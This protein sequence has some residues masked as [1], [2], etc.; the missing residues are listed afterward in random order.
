MKARPLLERFWERVS[1]VQ[2]ACWLWRGSTTA[3]GYG[4]LGAGG[5]GGANVYAHRLSWE[6]H[7][8]PIPPGMHVL[9]RCDNP[10]CVNPEHLFL[11]TQ[12]D[13]N[14]DKTRKGRHARGERH[15]NAKLTSEKAARIRQ[16]RADGFGTQDA[17]ARELGVTR[18]CVAHVL[19]GL[20]WAEDR[21]HA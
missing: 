18:S 15:G 16:M 6:V 11:G 9:H 19:Q 13:N 10:P 17:I 8:G 2:G 5:R 1:V 4:N 7:K 12:R 3:A 14:A 21:P 20:T